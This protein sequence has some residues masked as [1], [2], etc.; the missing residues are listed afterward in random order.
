[1]A[2]VTLTTDVTT[3]GQTVDVTVYEDIGNTG[4][5]DNQ[6]TVSGVATGTNT[7][8]LTTL[9]GSPDN[10][11]WVGLNLSTA[12]VTQTPTIHSI[13]VQTIPTA[14]TNLSANVI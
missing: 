12:D 13:S 1:M 5:T 8:T 10:A 3:N 7:N 11:Y 9:D 6:E 2:D 14:P 4:T